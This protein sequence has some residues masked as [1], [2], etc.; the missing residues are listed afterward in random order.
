MFYDET[1][2]WE[3]LSDTYA[4]S[5]ILMNEYLW[6]Y[7]CVK[8]LDA[9]SLAE[10]TNRMYALGADSIILYIKSKSIEYCQIYHLTKNA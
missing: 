4:L 2:G 8:A 3:I 6:I 7:E 9:L 1:Y 5:L 10:L